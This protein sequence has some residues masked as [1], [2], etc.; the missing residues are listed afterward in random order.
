M[1]RTWKI[2]ALTGALLLAVA[3]CGS[4]SQQGEQGGQT[5][6][7][8]Q[9]QQGGQT[10]QVV[11]GD[12]ADLA[13][14]VI[15]LE[16]LFFT[17]MV[18][19]AREAAQDSNASLS[20]FNANDDPAAQNRAIENYVQQGV[21]G[22]MVVAIDTEGVRPAI[23]SAQEADIPVAAIDAI[24]DTPAVDVQI[25][26]DNRKAAQDLG[27]FFN[28]WAS[29]QSLDSAGTGVVGA[30]NSTIQIERQD[31][32]TNTIKDAGHEIVQ[33]VDGKNQQAEAQRAAEN[34]FTANPNLDATYAT[35]EPALIG[36]V[37]AARSQGMTERVSLFG[38]DLS[39]QVIDGIDEGFVVAV[40]QQDPKKEGTRA[41]EALMGLLN[42]EEV[43][44]DID[45]PITIVTQENV[46][47][48]RS[49]F[50]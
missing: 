46:D 41:V 2:L 14:V 9:G 18:E 49:L 34:L 35:G 8:Q 29:E 40:V 21:D 31:G 25:G 24:V 48:F 50:E 4:A 38:W 47:D 5:G 12:E 11:Q 22:I 27:K 15:N 13:L 7:N 17:Q 16:A 1:I 32:F 30:L 28:N 20:V 10:Q 3:G 44:S 45:I 23:Q 37:A 33:V 26:V 19:G 6:G 36:L 42:G 39:Q 43:P